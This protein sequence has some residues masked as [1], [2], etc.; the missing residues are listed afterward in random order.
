[1]GTSIILYKFGLAEIWVIRIGSTTPKSPEIRLHRANLL[2]FGSSGTD[3]SETTGRTQVNRCEPNKNHPA[4]TKSVHSVHRDASLFKQ[5]A[6]YDA[7]DLA[8]VSEMAMYTVYI[9]G[10]CR[11]KIRCN[12][13]STGIKTFNQ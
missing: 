6:G 4:R 12:E 8:L 2:K 11:L 10:S 1:M 3:A 5:D 13:T 9:F 7:G